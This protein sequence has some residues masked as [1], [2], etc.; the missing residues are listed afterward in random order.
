M[1]FHINGG[2]AKV[3]ETLIGTDGLWFDLPCTIHFVGSEISVRALNRFFSS[4]AALR[5]RR[6]LAVMKGLVGVAGACL[7]AL[8]IS[9][10]EIIH[11][12]REPTIFSSL[13]LEIEIPRGK[14]VEAPPLDARAIA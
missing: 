10:S 9:R 3:A 6:P 12:R 11:S 13:T 14:A 5:T 8:K 4:V 2:T 1:V 7:A